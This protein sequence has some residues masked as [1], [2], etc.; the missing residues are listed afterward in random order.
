[1]SQISNLETD[2]I[3]VPWLCK[4]FWA[5]AEQNPRIPKAPNSWVDQQNPPDMAHVHGETDDLALT[6]WHHNSRQAH[7][8]AHSFGTAIAAFGGC[9]F[10]RFFVATNEDMSKL[11]VSP[12]SLVGWL[13]AAFAV[14]KMVGWYPSRPTISNKNF[15][16]GTS[17]HMFEEPKRFINNLCLVVAL[18]VQPCSNFSRSFNDQNLWTFGHQGWIAKNSWRMNSRCKHRTSGAKKDTFASVLW[19]GYFSYLCMWHPHLLHLRGWGPAHPSCLHLLGYV[20]IPTY[21]PS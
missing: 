13:V 3:W 21:N 5:L 1:M 15:N 6:I 11:G 7:I 14:P 19:V 8:S 4:C 12:W 16:D 9:F 2:P 10:H 18:L 17:L 20:R